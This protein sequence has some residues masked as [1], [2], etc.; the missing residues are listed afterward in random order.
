MEGNQKRLPQ[1]YEEG[2]AERAEVQAAW[3]DTIRRQQETKK[4]RPPEEKR[5]SRDKEWKTK[6]AKIA[7]MTPRE[8]A[9]RKYNHG[10]CNGVLSIRFTDKLRPAGLA[11]DLPGPVL[12]EATGDRAYGTRFATLSNI[13][14]HVAGFHKVGQA[15]LTARV[16]RH[17]ART[18]EEFTRALADHKRYWEGQKINN[19]NDPRV[20]KLLEEEGIEEEEV[21]EDEEG[22]VAGEVEE[23]DEEDEEDKV[24]GGQVYRQN[25]LNLTGKTL[26][27]CVKH[28]FRTCACMLQDDALE[29]N[30]CL[31]AC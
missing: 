18:D 22:D 26:A 19:P 6:R 17:N 13:R 16:V 20:K 29:A 21:D 23:D 5:K 9:V 3:D 7:A 25:Y 15:G 30:H 11:C 12:G 4:N 31:C 8:N 2:S 1:K 27:V 24:I 14:G 28:H 10:L